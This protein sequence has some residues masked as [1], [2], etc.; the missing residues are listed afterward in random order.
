MIEGA[1]GK[2]VMFLAEIL[3]FEQSASIAFD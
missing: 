2:W 1:D 3:C